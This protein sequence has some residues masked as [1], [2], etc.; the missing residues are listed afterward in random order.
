MRRTAILSMVAVVLMVGLFAS[1]AVA[2]SLEGTDGRDVIDGTGQADDVS[3]MA[4][5]DTLNGRDGKDTVG[6][7]DGDDEVSGGAG[8]DKTYGDA[9]DDYLIDA[10]DNDRDHLYGGNWRGKR[11]GGG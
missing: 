10:P 6:G 4:G 7:G 1:A 8:A 5:D 9:G 3:G 2:A 11:Q